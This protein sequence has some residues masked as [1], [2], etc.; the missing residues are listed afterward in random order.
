V[1]LRAS[2]I[3]A[4]AAASLIIGAQA[5]LAQKA[6]GIL[7]IYN[8]DSPPSMSILEESA[9]STVLPMMGVFNNLVIYNQHVAQN[10]AQTIGP[11]LATD[12][13]W[14]EDGTRLTFELRQ[15][16]K[17]HDGQP[18]T[19]QDVKCT[20]D[21]LTGKAQEKLRINPRRSWYDNLDDLTG[22]DEVT[23]VLKRPQPSFIS[24]LASGLAPVYPCHAP[25]EE[26]RQHPIGTGPFKFVEFRPNE[27]IRVTK[28]PDY[29]KKGRPY[30]DGIDYTI[31]PN[32]VERRCSPSRPGNSI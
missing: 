17:W 29:W 14:S 9:L 3:A 12:W 11:E 27:S 5:A 24:L 22:D 7:K 21:L 4:V 16:V 26:M 1:I 13:E 28:N 30:L 19:A 23:F 15:G 25:P 8:R 32:R 6:G 2:L 18:F 10:N 31:I 20:W